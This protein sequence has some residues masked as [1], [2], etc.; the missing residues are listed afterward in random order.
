MKS[1]A[2]LVLAFVLYVFPSFAVGER[3]VVFEYWDAAKTKPRNVQVFDEQQRQDGEWMHWYENGSLKSKTSFLHGE[4]LLMEAWHENGRKY[5]QQ[6]FAEG[7]AHGLWIWWD[8]DG[9]VL[10]K[11]WFNMG[12]GVEHYYD[13]K[14]REKRRVFW[15]NGFIVREEVPGEGKKGESGGQR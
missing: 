14:G 13:D 11:S 10:A 15:M 7:M 4:V 6:P 5:I 12:T 3:N 8:A 9:K 2:A 1:K